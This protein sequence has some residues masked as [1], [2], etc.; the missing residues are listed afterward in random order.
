MLELYKNI[1]KTGFQKQYHLISQYY[2]IY[3]LI[4]LPNVFTNKK[5]YY[6]TSIVYLAMYLPNIILMHHYLNMNLFI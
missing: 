6:V 4:T 1:I 2:A 3:I 5:I